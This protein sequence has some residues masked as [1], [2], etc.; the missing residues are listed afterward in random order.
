MPRKE[1]LRCAAA[2]SLVSMLV[3]C[4]TLPTNTEPHAIRSFEQDRPDAPVIAPQA[5]QQP[6]LLVRDF[7]QASAHPTNDFEAARSFLTPAASGAWKP[8]EKKL[9]VDGLDLKTVVD[10]NEQQTGQTF[11]VNA[12]V[13][14][15]L[16]PGGAFV[17]GSG[18]FEGQ[19]DV[20]KVDG[21]WRISN[22][23]NDVVVERS[24]LDREYTHTNLY[25]FDAAG[26]S[27]VTDKRWVYSREKSLDD[28][29]VNMLLEGPA[30]RLQPA[31]GSE[32]PDSVTY[33]GHNDGRYEFS[34]FHEADEKMRARFA[35]QV[36]WTLA[37]AGVN[38]PYSI[39]ADGS[40]LVGGKPELNTGDFADLD[41]SENAPA[42]HAVYALAG[43]NIFE[44]IDDRAE[45]LEGRMGSAGQIESID[46]T[47]DGSFAAV[48]KDG[49]GDTK[50]FVM[51][52]KGQDYKE[53]LTAR[54]LTRP[55]FES[56]HNVAWV[57]ADGERIVRAVR[58][59][60]SGDIN[61]SDVSIDLPGDVDAEISVVRLSRTGARAIIIADGR[62]FVGVVE[63]SGEERSIINVSEYAPDLGGVVAAD[64]QPDGSLIVGT[65]NPLQ[66]V[67]RVEQ[68][69]FSTEPLPAGNITA[70]VVA[71][72]ATD[73]TIYAT[74]SRSIMELPAKQRNQPFWREVPG[75][76]GIRSA[77]I[78]ATR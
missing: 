61:T 60:T 9:I 26:Q 57:V 25:F 29:L 32:L 21:Q 7:F 18:Q 33:S 55:T 23:P 48:L 3:G 13:I 4:T 17:P 71:V 72:A 1:A 58:S 46:I 14:G 40:P 27:L 11:L 8:G 5:D 39:Y 45:A 64:W 36:V 68:D 10:E 24:A 51:G 28:E 20:E 67:V 2:V 78:V 54:T 37:M 22:L 66:P 43:G 50:P 15:E 38:G 62:L 49:P 76:Q 16:W 75:L 35:A 41:P 12:R 56:D 69:G 52:E 31:L 73:S 65:S 59:S 74:D 53:V 44:L 19:F 6:D 30:Q 42:D 47:T 63:R 77:P 34:G 70:P